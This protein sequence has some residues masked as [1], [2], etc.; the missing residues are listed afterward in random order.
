[1]ASRKMY[2]WDGRE[3]AVD[4]VSVPPVGISYS[5]DQAI[6]G[7]TCLQDQKIYLGTTC[8]LAEKALNGRR[9]SGNQEAGKA[10][11]SEVQLIDHGKQYDIYEIHSK[12]ENKNTTDTPRPLVA[13]VVQSFHTEDPILGQHHIDK[14]LSEVAVLAMIFKT[15]LV[16]VPRCYGHWEPP[17]RDRKVRPQMVMDKSGG[18]SDEWTRSPLSNDSKIRML[19]ELAAIHVNLARIPFPPTAQIGSVQSYRHGPPAQVVIGPLF[20]P[21]QVFSPAT[22]PFAN[23]EAYIMHLLQRVRVHSPNYGGWKDIL[24]LARRILPSDIPELHRPMLAHTDFEPRN[25][26]STDGHVDAVI[27]WEFHAVLPAFLACHYPVWSLYEGR[28]DPQ[29]APRELFGECSVMWAEKRA[30]AERYRNIFAQEV[31]KL[32]PTYMRAVKAGAPARQL[33]DW[34]QHWEDYPGYLEGFQRWM[35][36]ML[37]MLDKWRARRAEPLTVETVTVTVSEPA[38]D[39]AR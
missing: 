32:D 4:D 31:K 5:I 14:M 15:S 27:D 28:L 30:D 36:H 2:T 18:R 11:V 13:R 33:V 39:Q 22:G 10:S 12:Y 35:V 20:E 6:D 34:L 7:Q 25:I 8:E 17:R 24:V 26:L 1:M 16:P 38:G 3:F 23:Y 19:H 9:S 29:F 37:K 21:I